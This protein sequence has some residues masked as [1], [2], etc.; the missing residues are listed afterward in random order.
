ML[1]EIA[2]YYGLERNIAFANFFEISPQLAISRRKTGALDYEEIYKR[3]KEI[4]PDWL[5]SGGEGPM[6]R[7]ERG[8][9]VIVVDRPD[10]QKD[11]GEQPPYPSS[12]AELVMALNSLS[13]EQDALARTQ[14]ALAKSQSQT[15]DLIDILKTGRG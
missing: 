1:E 10:S 4:S 12:G 2:R 9:N 8:E 14:E 15:S 6:L 11:R 7:A 13:K 5:L 3:C